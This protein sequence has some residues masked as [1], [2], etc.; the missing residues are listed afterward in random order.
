MTEEFEQTEVV[1]EVSD[2]EE[3]HPGPRRGCRTAVALLV[4]LMLLFSAAVPIT[5]F[6]IRK[7]YES[8]VEEFPKT[9]CANLSEA[10]QMEPECNPSLGIIEFVPRTFPL[11]SP[12]ETVALAMKGLAFEEQTGLSQPTCQQPTLWTY[13]VAKSSLGWRT[14]I[15]FLFCSGLLVERMVYVDGRP[16]RLPTYDL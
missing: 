2:V 16:V 1:E 6:V 15:E 9:V 13:N 8:K 5:R 7:S 4:V 10:G 14:E 12:K 3:S 11:S